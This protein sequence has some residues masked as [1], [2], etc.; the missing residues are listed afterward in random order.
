MPGLTAPLDEDEFLA[1]VP[2]IIPACVAGIH[3]FWKSKRPIADHGQGGVEAAPAP[4]APPNKRRDL[5]RQ[6]GWEEFG[7]VTAGQPACAVAMLRPDRVLSSARGTGP[8]V[9]LRPRY[10]APPESQR[11]GA[12]W[13]R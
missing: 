13:S 9:W 8:L 11:I 7:R 4:Q 3:E 5:G 6:H 10:R 1:E 12:S 2:D